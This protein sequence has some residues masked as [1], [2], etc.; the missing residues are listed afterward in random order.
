MGVTVAA[1]VGSTV[2]RGTQNAINQA[3]ALKIGESLPIAVG[4]WD[5]VLKQ[6]ICMP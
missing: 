6:F 3:S 2:K 4:V 1:E 5:L